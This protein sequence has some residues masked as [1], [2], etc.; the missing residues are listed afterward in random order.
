MKGVEWD[1]PTQIPFAIFPTVHGNVTAYVFKAQVLGNRLLLSNHLPNPCSSNV[2]H[3][4]SCLSSSW[5]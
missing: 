2:D 3:H 5:Q 1:A 4:H